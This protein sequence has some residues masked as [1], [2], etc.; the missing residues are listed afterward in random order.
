M[1]RTFFA[2][3]SS[4][5]TFAW[6]SRRCSLSWRFCFFCFRAISSLFILF[7]MDDG[8][9]L[10][11]GMMHRGLSRQQQRLRKWSRRTSIKRL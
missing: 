5:S 6:A 2:R 10:L 3:G 11:E 4:A 7:L 9:N 8:S 1:I